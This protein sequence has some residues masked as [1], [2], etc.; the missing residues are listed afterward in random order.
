MEEEAAY[1]ATAQAEIRIS[2][3]FPKASSMPKT[4]KIK[5][6]EFSTLF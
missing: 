3:C 2:A 4:V 1:L 5:S 6:N